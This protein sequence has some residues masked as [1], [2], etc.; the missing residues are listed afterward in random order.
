[1]TFDAL[2]A[3]IGAIHILNNYI[4]N[5]RGTVELYGSNEELLQVDSVI[6]VGKDALEVLKQHPRWAEAD[7]VLFGDPDKFDDGVERG[8]MGDITAGVM[9]GAGIGPLAQEIALTKEEGEEALKQLKH[10]SDPRIDA[11][12]TPKE[13]RT[14][15]QVAALFAASRSGR[16]MTGL[17]GGGLGFQCGVGVGVNLPPLTEK[18]DEEEK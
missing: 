17:A 10:R 15:E 4:E 16:L 9:Y 3:V 11:L 5:T 2:V 8:K 18:T 7:A 12:M 1:M 13:R 6:A 14:P